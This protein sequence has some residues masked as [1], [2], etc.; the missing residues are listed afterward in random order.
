MTLSL[1]L[2]RSSSHGPKR[3]SQ[4]PSIKVQRSRLTPPFD[5]SNHLSGVGHRHRRSH[6]S[7]GNVDFADQ[8]V[9]AFRTVI[10]PLCHDTRGWPFLAGRALPR[11]S[12]FRNRSDISR[13]SW[14]LNS[15]L[16]SSMCHDARPNRAHILYPSICQPSLS[17]P[18]S[19]PRII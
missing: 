13:Q 11:H 15:S 16:T 8:S 6:V 17:T 10:P 7:G 12:S 4:S 19:A 1:L 18:T 2:I 14:S 9:S 5:E 3:R